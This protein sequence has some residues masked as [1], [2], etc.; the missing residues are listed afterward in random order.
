VGQHF[1]GACG[2]ED[3]GA[4]LVVIIRALFPG[5]QAGKDDGSALKAFGTVDGVTGNGGAR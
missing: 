5:W 2:A 3:K 4:G 1:L